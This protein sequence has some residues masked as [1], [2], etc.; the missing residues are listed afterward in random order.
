MLKTKVLKISYFDLVKSENYNSYAWKIDVFNTILELCS[1][2]FKRKCGYYRHGR[3]SLDLRNW[4]YEC[5]PASKDLFAEHTRSEVP[6]ILNWVMHKQLGNGY[7]C[8]LIFN[9][10]YDEISLIFFD[11]SI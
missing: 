2:K 10:T 11:L 8:L 4:F 6:R 9:L 3:F 7:V 5:C 1:N